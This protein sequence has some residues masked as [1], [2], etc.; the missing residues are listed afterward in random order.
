MITDIA[1][2][3][4]PFFQNILIFFQIPVAIDFFRGYNRKD[5]FGEE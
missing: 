4:K 5:Y 1:E 3:C 2:K